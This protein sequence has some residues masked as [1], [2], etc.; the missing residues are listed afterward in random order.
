MFSWSSVQRI[1]TGDLGIKSI[2]AKFFRRVLTK[3]QKEYRVITCCAFKQQFQNDSVFLSIVITDDESWCY[4]YESETNQ[5]SIQ[6]NTSSAHC[7]KN[8][9]MSKQC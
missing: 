1:S 8:V 2:S 6:W 4:G 7:P 9:V 5:Q 3:N